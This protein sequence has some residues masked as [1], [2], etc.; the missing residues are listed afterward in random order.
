MKRNKPFWTAVRQWNDN[1]F[2]RM[3]VECT[4]IETSTARLK[5]FL[6]DAHCVAAEDSD[7]GSYRIASFER[8]D[9]TVFCVIIAGAEAL[10]YQAQSI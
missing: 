1:F 9:G 4:V 2:R 7:D 8:D 6:G 10:I 5:D 3:G